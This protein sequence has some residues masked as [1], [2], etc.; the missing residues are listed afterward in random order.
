MSL[1]AR[2]A[3]TRE[4][5]ELDLQGR[6]AH[7]ALQ[8]RHSFARVLHATRVLRIGLADTDDVTRMVSIAKR[9]GG[10]GVGGSADAQPLE[11]SNHLARLP[12]CDHALCARP[13]TA[14]RCGHLF[15]GLRARAVTGSVLVLLPAV[16]R[17]WRGFF[18]RL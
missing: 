4:Q 7:P 12:V 15:G 6:P 11:E 17:D 3:A 18:D 10:A 13:L 14:H 5:D 2:E 1:A 16:P 8:V 9:R